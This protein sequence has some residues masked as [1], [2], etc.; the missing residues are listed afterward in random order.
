MG[1]PGSGKGTQA[2][3]LQEKFKIPKISTGDILRAAVTDD[4]DL[5]KDAKAFMNKGQLVPDGVVIGLIQ[6]RI[7]EADCADGYILDGFPRTIVQAEK[8]EETLV[9]GQSID[10]VV[11]LVVDPDELLVRLIGRSTCRDCGSM[12]H[13]T[14]HPPKKEGVCD[15]CGGELYQRP[16]DNEETIRQR[17]KVYT[18]E[19]EPLREYYQKQGKLKSAPGRGSVEEIFTR[20]CKLVA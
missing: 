10:A 1:P 8:L 18:S 7:K 11:D 19:T 5:G 16:D 4:T 9:E 15:G 14:T 17:L 20:V 2:N 3:L 12:F 13:Q 6:E